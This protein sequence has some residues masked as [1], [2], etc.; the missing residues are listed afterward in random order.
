MD[1]D[2][3]VRLK[4]AVEAFN[5]YHA[6]E[7]RARLVGLD[8]TR[9]TIEFDG[10]SCR[11]CGGQDY[12]EDFAYE[13]SDHLHRRTDLVSFERIGACGFVGVYEIGE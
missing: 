13:A 11:S 7:V 4:E 12:L 1:G 6:P 10:A 3:V 9:L 2:E 5:R 8:G